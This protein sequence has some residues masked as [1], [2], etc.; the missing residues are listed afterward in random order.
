[1]NSTN[2]AIYNALEWITKFAYLQLLWI[3]FSLTGGI[4]LGFFPATVAMFSIIRQWIKGNA[5]FPLLKTF[6]KYYKAE[7][8]KSNLLGLFMVIVGAIIGMDIFYLKLNQS[9]WI[10]IPLFAFMLIFILFVF[11]LFPVYVHYDMKVNRVIKNAFFIMLINP[12]HSLLI[13]ICF[14][15]I[16]F[17]MRM[18]PALAFIF[19]GSIYAFITMWLCYHA[20]KRMERAQH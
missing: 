3:L 17:I 4:V 1:M 19:G 14:I 11:Y 5:D 2:N 6:W 12:L 8:W 15:S 13:V 18:L 10:R 9:D 7:F 16:Y 20:F